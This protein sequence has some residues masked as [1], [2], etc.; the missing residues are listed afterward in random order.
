MRGAAGRGGAR[1]GGR[2]AE[3]PPAPSLPWQAGEVRPPQ[4][5]PG[6]TLHA[7]LP[8]DSGLTDKPVAPVA[9]GAADRT[10]GLS[11]AAHRHL[12][13]SPRLECDSNL[14]LDFHA[15]VKVQ[16]SPFKKAAIYCGYIYVGG[17][18]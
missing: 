9:P 10:L 1:P 8:T 13:I 18:F 14:K 6:H 5:Q 12:C 3:R 7:S 4:L 17:K 11:V 16:E 15:S 2:A